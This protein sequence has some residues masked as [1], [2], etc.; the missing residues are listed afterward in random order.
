MSV[1]GQLVVQLSADYKGLLAGQVAMQNFA[2][3]AEK[4]AATAANAWQ[5]AGGQLYTFGI[6]ASMYLTAPLAAIGT[7]SMKA[8]EEFESNMQ[9]IVGLVGESQGQVDQWSN[10]LLK[11]GPELGQT[12]KALADAL[13]FIT[14]S[15]VDAS[16]A[17][18]ILTASAKASSAGLGDV[19]SMADLA[20][21]AMNAYKSEG[22]SAARIFDIMTAAVREGKT[23]ASAFAN[24]VGQIIPIASEMGV[25]LEEVTAAMAAMSLT[26][27]NAAHSAV[28]LK[29]ILNAIQS[30]GTE[31]AK[32]LEMMGTSGAQ[33]REMLEKD[34]MGTLKKLADL[35][36]QYGID[37]L[38]KV[39]PN[40]RAM[41]GFLSLMGDNYE[42][43]LEIFREVYDSTG[44]MDTAFKVV[45]NTMKF[46]HQKAI[47]EV[48]AT[49]IQL[50]RSMKESVM[51]LLIKMA[52]YIQ[53]LGNWF[54]NLSESTQKWIVIIGMAVAALGPFMLILSFLSKFIIPYLILSIPKLVTGFA[55]LQTTMME[56]QAL[57]IAAAGPI[58]ALAIAIGVTLALALDN[59]AAA[60]NRA[61]EA[62]MEF[63]NKKRNAKIVEPYPDATQFT[64]IV[65]K[66]AMMGAYPKDELVA[67]KKYVQSQMDTEQGYLK[68]LE[69]KYAARLNALKVHNT[70]FSAEERKDM[71]TRMERY[72][73]HIDTYKRILNEAD[74][75][76][77]KFGSTLSPLALVIEDSFDSVS[78]IMEEYAAAVTMVEA[79]N[80]I[81]GESFNKD[82]FQGKLN[83]AEATLTRLIERQLL[84]GDSS[85]E[86]KD[87]IDI[88]TMSIKSMNAA[89]RE[90]GT[91]KDPLGFLEFYSNQ[92]GDLES[93][94]SLI[95]EK[96]REHER[97]AESFFNSGNFAGATAEI[98][99]IK[100]LILQYDALS[101]QMQIIN[102][103]ADMMATMIQ[104]VGR[105][106]VEGGSAMED[107]MM[108]VLQIINR[109]LVALLIEAIVKMMD[110]S[111]D[112]TKNPIAGLALGVVLSSAMIA[113]FSRSKSQA[114]SA[115]AMAE[116]GVIPAGY[117]NDTY[118]ALLTSGETVFPPGELPQAGAVNVKVQDILIDGRKLRIILQKD[119]EYLNATT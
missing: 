8:A 18:E 66:R 13:Y 102:A 22:L 28:Y 73:S 46:R 62:K 20:T 71:T 75:A 109:L 108:S 93:Q 65:N 107:A 81:L 115:A 78:K 82:A 9:K 41:T 88:V 23:E 38:D 101:R 14:S 52:E 48:Q 58:A 11:L 17:M 72:R 19:R 119:A 4:T 12:P 16:K 33:L 106:F 50:G 26:G 45:A 1:I 47:A 3:T 104:A 79:K 7:A 84:T 87:A 63:E 105:A 92:M 90:T 44:D 118:P 57:V 117:P 34:L 97:L 32:T 61:T 67:Y 37:T 64:E 69:I 74:S 68:N 2:A 94:M 56:W 96:I 95:N 51:P 5:K 10:Q 24:Q 60:Y 21:S 31:A 53:K 110:K 89:L 111:L 55:M 35:T 29:G 43:N 25:S 77:T 39:I 6:R 49:Y 54:S 27:S 114:Q 103:T 113:A 91:T 100:A 116:G 80:L 99:A 98:E 83:E 40:I 59:V 85:K 36:K 15:G 70:E 30:P 42:K 112:M 86:M 76:I